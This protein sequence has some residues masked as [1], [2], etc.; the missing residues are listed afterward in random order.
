VPSYFLYDGDDPVVEEG[1]DG[2]LLSADMFGLDGPRAQYVPGYNYFYQQN[3]TNDETVLSTFD[4][5]GS[6]VQRLSVQTNPDYSQFAGVYDAFGGLRGMYSTTGQ[7]GTGLSGLYPTFGFGGQHGYY[8]DRWTG[9]VL[10]THRHYDP[11]TGRFVTRD[12]IGYRGGIGLYAFC[13]NNPI[14]EMDPSGLD[15]LDTAANFSAGAGDSVSG[16]LTIFVRRAL[17]CDD[18]VDKSSGAYVCGEAT[19][20]TVEVVASGGS[21]LAKRAA[22]RAITGKM[23]EEGITRTAAKRALRRES[24]EQI[25]RNFTREELA[26]GTPHHVHPLNGH[27]LQLTRMRPRQTL[28]P[29]IGL[30]ARVNGARRNIRILNHVRHM[31]A[32]RR[33]LRAEAIATRAFNRYTGTA[34]AVGDIYRPI[35]NRRH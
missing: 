20:L 12:P 29:T 17:H 14:T 5:Q 1:P 34:R 25:T 26:K 21:A 18:V 19:E 24:E 3:G 15:W 33:L 35:A 27:P 22:A 4:P 16:G 7:A 6:L 10:M 11:S 32:H 13:G 30:G 28:Y 9:L 8:T 2:S 23:L 31:A